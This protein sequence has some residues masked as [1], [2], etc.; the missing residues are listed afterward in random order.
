MVRNRRTKGL[1]AVAMGLTLGVLVILLALPSLVAAQQGATATRSLSTNT[2]APGGTVTVTVTASG[3]GTFG[4]V[5][6]TLPE[7]FTYTGSSL[8]DSAV[9]NKG[10]VYTFILFRVTVASPTLST[11]PAWRM[12][13]PS[14]VI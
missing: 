2:V 12:T 5:V 7:G 8:G 13:T 11:R 1:L 10:Q 9:T 3:Y 14:P 4:G 6:E